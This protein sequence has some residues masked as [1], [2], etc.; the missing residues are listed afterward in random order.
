MV[1][2]TGISLWRVRWTARLTPRGVL[3]IYMYNAKLHVLFMGCTG[4]TLHLM[5]SA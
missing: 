1:I 2:G 3:L 4:Y 5:C